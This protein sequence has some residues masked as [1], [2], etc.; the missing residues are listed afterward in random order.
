M[1]D[2]T[3][4]RTTAS[5]ISKKLLPKVQS[6]SR[7]LKADLELLDYTDPTGV[8]GRDRLDAAERHLSH[9]EDALRR[10]TEGS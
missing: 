9:A 8:T 10:A 1:R 7:Q 2:K 6:L 3:E 4:D 5:G